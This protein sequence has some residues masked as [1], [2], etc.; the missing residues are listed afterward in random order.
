MLETKCLLTSS[1]TE[2]MIKA[3][4]FLSLLF[5]HANFKDEEAIDE[6][7]KSAPVPPTNTKELALWKSMDMKVYALVIAF[8]S[9]GVSR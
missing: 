9:E 7:D 8:V 1:L 4:A 2:A 6:V 3:K 5:H